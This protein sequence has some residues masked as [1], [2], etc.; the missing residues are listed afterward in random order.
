MTI[1]FAANDRLKIHELHDGK[2]RVR[3]TTFD[4]HDVSIAPEV[5]AT[6]PA[7]AFSFVNTEKHV[8]WVRAHR[9]PAAFALT[10]VH[11]Q[12]IFID[13]VQVLQ[14][15]FNLRLREI[16]GDDAHILYFATNRTTTNAGMVALT[17]RRFTPILSLPEVILQA[18]AT[19]DG[20]LI[21]RTTHG[22]ILLLDLRN[23]TVARVAESE[24][25]DP[26][27]LAISG[28]TAAVV[29]WT[30]KG[31]QLFFYAAP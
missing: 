30:E 19:S 5:E 11:R 23:R 28:H 6:P 4:G 9:D 18:E 27:D 7:G 29:Q 13:G 15:Y 8:A 21:A 20:R 10:S 17:T 3:V 2:V 1:S 16:P 24:V 31:S 12:D 25:T 14:T 26:V 22:A